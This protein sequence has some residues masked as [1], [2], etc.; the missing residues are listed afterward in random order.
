MKSLSL[1]LNNNKLK[2]NQCLNKLKW[3][4]N[5]NRLMDLKDVD[6]KHKLL[7]KMIYS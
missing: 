5:S 2:M 6:S 7:S 4:A 3:N 1:L